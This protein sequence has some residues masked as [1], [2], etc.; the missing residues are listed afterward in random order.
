MM[1]SFESI[2]GGIVTLVV[3]LFGA[4]HVGRSQGKTTA[5]ADA[6]EREAATIAA[7]ADEAAN[8]R[9]QA[10]REASDVQQTI[11]HMPDY[12]VDSELRNNWTRKG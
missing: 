6:K 8:R 5:Q 11:N 4:L 1:G 7:A 9:V 3:L 2:I 10:T 12:D